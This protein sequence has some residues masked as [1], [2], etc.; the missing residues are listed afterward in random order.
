MDVLYIDHLN[1]LHVILER[2]SFHKYEQGGINLIWLKSKLIDC[3]WTV[4]TIISWCS[5]EGLS[6]LAK[7]I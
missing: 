4:N 1:R 2:V 5:Y 6:V 7:E 3:W